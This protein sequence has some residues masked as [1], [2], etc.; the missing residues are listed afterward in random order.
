MNEGRPGGRSLVRLFIGGRE[1]INGLSRWIIHPEGL[2][3]QEVRRLPHVMKRIAAV[4]EYRSQ[5]GGALAKS[6]SAA[7]TKFH[8]KVI[9]QGAFLVIPE[10]SSERREYAPI[11]WVEPPTTPSNQLLVIENATRP[12]FALLTSAMHMAWLR[13]M[14]GRLKSDYRY[15][16]GLVYNTFPPPPPGADT[17]A[18]APLAEAVLAA[19]AAHPGAS[20]ADLYDPDLM[21][22]GLRRAHAALDRAVDRLYAKRALGTDRE[23]AE[24]LLARYE[25]MTAPLTAAPKPR[26]RRTP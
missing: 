24:F 20:L 1:F 2:P 8:V 15:S 19:R 10:V 12:L 25:A 23:R 4:R 5:T 9:P 11:G 21:P 17:D 16:T 6:L 26:R 7:P 14:G 13:H 3:V 22:T 18:L